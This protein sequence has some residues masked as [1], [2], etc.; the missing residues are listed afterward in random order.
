MIRSLSRPVCAAAMAAILTQHAQAALPRYDHVLIVV[1]ENHG[2]AQV[3]GNPS[4]PY[5]TSLSVQ[6]ANFINSHGLA[7]PSQ[8][9]YLALFSGS[10]QGI[11]N[12]S[13]P[14]TFTGADN[15]GAQLAT[16]GLSFSGYSESMPAA[17]Y[18]G[19]SAGNYVRK[20]NPWVNFPNV[21]ST[22]NLPYSA[23]PADYA[24]LPTVSFLVPN[25]ISDMH[26]GSVNTGDVWLKTNIDAYAQWAQTHNSLL[27]LTF[28]E[29]DSSTSA[30]LVP[31]IFVGAG[32]VPGT[33]PKTINHYNI[34]ATIEGMYG[35]PA[36]TTAAPIVDA[37]AAQGAEPHVATAH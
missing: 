14:H 29:D 33:Y 23:F 26:N 13:C 28:D 4:A 30:N 20:H 24:T 8:P 9:N 7:H 21:P 12:D 5:I 31:T 10:T 36:L 11:T 6:G 35:L 25:L 22:A 27:I 18:T 37:F 2:L 34:L 16:G 3:V 32:I 19:C 17:G 15:L 1:M